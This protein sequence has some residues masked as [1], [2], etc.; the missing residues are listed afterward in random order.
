MDFL[1]RSTSEALEKSWEEVERLQRERENVSKEMADTNSFVDTMPFVSYE[2]DIASS[3]IRLDDPSSAQNKWR[4]SLSD[5]LKNLGGTRR[6]GRRP[7]AIQTSIE[8]DLMRQLEFLQDENLAM[9]EEI[10]LKLRQREA[11]IETLESTVVLQ[12]Q[13]IQDLRVEIDELREK[14]EG[15]QTGRN[16]IKTFRSRM[17]SFQKNRSI[18]SVES[19]SSRKSSLSRDSQSSSQSNHNSRRH[20]GKTERI[21]RASRNELDKRGRASETLTEELRRRGRSCESPIRY[22]DKSQDVH[23][24]KG[25]RRKSCDYVP[26]QH[27][28]RDPYER[29]GEESSESPHPLE[30]VESLKSTLDPETLS[31]YRAVSDD[32]KASNIYN[33][34]SDNTKPSRTRPSTRDADGTRRL[35][36]NAS[37]LTKKSYRSKFSD[38]DRRSREVT[39][40]TIGA[41]AA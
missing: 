16:Q 41:H 35:S 13:T 11:A 30:S 29:A 4:S 20:S 21:R 9:A 10:K 15:V 1:R 24:Q 19:L 25:T 28:R 38:G 2:M 18:R 40:D 23:H 37:E 32:P 39:L 33:P 7:S 34:R 3:T 36:N 31:F 6:W 14:Y 17:D 5:S 8:Q 27:R 22:I 26:V 12:G